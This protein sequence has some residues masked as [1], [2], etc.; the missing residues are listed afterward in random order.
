MWRKI[1]A[2]VKN[3]GK[4]GAG[5]RKA[6]EVDLARLCGRRVWRMSRKKLVC[7]A[8]AGQKQNQNLC[9]IKISTGLKDRGRKKRQKTR[10]K[11]TGGKAKKSKNKTK[12]KQNK[13]KLA[14][15]LYKLALIHCLKQSVE[16]VAIC[17]FLCF[18]LCDC[19]Q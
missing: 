12:T 14:K 2:G 11:K 10:V 18:P 19:A 7:G 15:S 1:C 4:C 8:C 9:V 6:C 16:F 13:N 3:A 17:I 5:R